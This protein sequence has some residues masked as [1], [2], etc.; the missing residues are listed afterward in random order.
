[1]KKRL[2]SL[3]LV[4]ILVNITAPLFSASELASEVID[5]EVA[6]EGVSEL[7]SEVVSEES[8]EVT[9]EDLSEVTSEDITKV[10]EGS[11]ATTKETKEVEK[12]TR[13]ANTVDVFTFEYNQDEFTSIGATVE[14]GFRLSPAIGSQVFDGATVEFYNADAYE[15]SNFVVRN[16][17]TDTTLVE[18]TD[19]QIDGSTITLNPSAN[20]NDHIAI[21]YDVTL[22]EGT[23]NV[24]G[25]ET[26]MYRDMNDNSTYDEGVDYMVNDLGYMIKVTNSGDVTDKAIVYDATIEGGEIAVSAVGDAYIKKDSAGALYG[27]A[28]FKL[29]VTG[30]IAISI[31]DLYYNSGVVVT[32]EFAASLGYDTS[33]YYTAL[34]LDS[35]DFVYT[36]DGVEFNPESLSSLED[37]YLN[38]G[39]VI[40]IKMTFKA[41][42]SDSETALDIFESLNGL[43]KNAEVL[44]LAKFSGNVFGSMPMSD[45]YVAT[46]SFATTSTKSE[47]SNPKVEASNTATLANTG[48]NLTMTM[49]LLVGSLFVAF[50][51]KLKLSLRA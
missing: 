21:T 28:N 1:M 20:V 19:Y 50:A 27:G 44:Y 41:T 14:G 42:V 34:A 31:M 6:S 17:T 49:M 33:S 39:Q 8:S 47:V 35:A 51:A 11:S 45:D 5:S 18:G 26:G 29:E 16:T 30:D 23:T 4:A 37:E 43:R 46:A 12:E 36:I 22:V 32:D 7:T 38:P 2:S 40:E 10:E 3:L 13:A 24:L 25:A 15:F 48:S 9:S